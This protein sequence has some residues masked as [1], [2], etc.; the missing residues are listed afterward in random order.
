M[1]AANRIRRFAGLNETEK[2]NRPLIVIVTKFDA[3]APL[4]GNP[5]LPPPYAKTSSGNLHA[6]DLSFVQT[7]SEQTRDL[8]WDYTPEIVSAAESFVDEVYYI[9]GECDGKETEV[10]PATGLLGVRSS[11]MNPIWV[12][13]PV[14]M[15]MCK[16]IPGLIPTSATGL[17]PPGF[18]VIQ[19]GR[20][21]A[22]P[23]AAATSTPPAAASPA[24]GRTLGDRH[25]GRCPST[26]I[27]RIGSPFVSPCRRNQLPPRRRR[28][29]NDGLRVDLHVRAP[30]PA[31]GQPRILY[32][33]GD[34]RFAPG[35]AGPFRV[36]QRLSARIS[37]ARRTADLNPVV[38]PHLRVTADSQTYHV[39]SRIADAGLDYTKRSN[40]IAHHLALAVQDLGAAGPAWL[41]SQA[42]LWR[43]DWQ[44]EPQVLPQRGRCP[45]SPA[46]PTPVRL[47]WH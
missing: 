10:D 25:G 35:A 26:T 23:T 28:S 40:K 1:E 9:P 21:A 14:L 45:T 4:L 41:L 24:R 3:W 6:V 18:R 36:A 39:L 31:A 47:G 13:V 46:G 38:C 27:H 42:G 20:T 15:A 16:W 32:G 30:G 2:H 11:D 22:A 37:A 43:S 12:E 34:R 5:R 19:G 7:I 17:R 29:R 44:E 33:R 8:L